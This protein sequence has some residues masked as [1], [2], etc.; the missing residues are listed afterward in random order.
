[1]VGWRGADGGTKGSGAP[2]QVTISSNQP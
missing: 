1:L 2:R